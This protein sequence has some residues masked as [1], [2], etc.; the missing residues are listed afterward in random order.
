MRGPQVVQ[1]ALEFL[2]ALSS[3]L[4]HPGEQFLDTCEEGSQLIHGPLGPLSEFTHQIQQ[5]V[6]A[7]RLIPSGPAEE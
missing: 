5:D 6:N 1:V 3:P 4:A 7:V 2:G